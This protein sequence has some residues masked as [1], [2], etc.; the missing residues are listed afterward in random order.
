MRRALLLATSLALV[1]VV[2]W[3]ACNARFVARMVT[4]PSE[5][6]ILSVDWYEP[7]EVVRGGDVEPLPRL[8]TPTDR[9]SADAL[10]S[11]S[12]YAREKRSAGLLVL[13]DGAVALEEYYGG[14]DASK[15]TNSFSMA[16]TI[17][18]LLIGV[19]IDEGAI[20][21]L[22]EP[23]ARY[24]TEWA[25]DDRAA[26]TLRDLLWMQSGLSLDD[27]THTPFSDLVQVHLGEDLLA[28]LLE[29]PAVRPPGRDYE[30]NN[31][32]SQLL[33][34]VLQRATGARYADYLS[35]R[36]WSRIG[37]DDASLWLDSEG[38]NAK[39][40]CCLFA[41]LRDWARVGEMLRHGGRVDGRQVVPSAWIEEMRRPSAYYVRYGG[42]LWLRDAGDDVNE[43]PFFYLDGGR[44]QRVYVIP[45]LGVVAVR[46]G[47][48]ARGWDNTRIP[49][50]IAAGM[51][52]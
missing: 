38:G 46:V 29:I 2:G 16:K 39:T 1:V 33:G 27:A 5:T 14:H 50:T 36:L 6:P 9:V 40:Y 13:I 10:A 47:E 31:M 43:P 17:L 28:P 22:D 7:L 8:A 19:A 48:Q 11:L 3:G 12:E 23:A 21:G 52:D 32:N 15:T 42:H 34:V 25:D 51:S 24:L 20:G 4:Y 35:S 45:S 44:K 37:A 26:I 41:T 30:Y 18:G 49:W